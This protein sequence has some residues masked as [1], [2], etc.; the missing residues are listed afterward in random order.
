MIAIHPQRQV[1]LSTESLIVITLDN[2]YIY[3]AQYEP[4]DSLQHEFPFVIDEILY[5]QNI[6]YPEIIT[7]NTPPA[8]FRDLRVTS[9]SFYPISFNPQNHQLKI[10]KKAIVR[11]DFV[12]TDS[13]NVLPSWPASISP[14]FKNMYQSTI[15]NYNTLGIQSE[16]LSTRSQYLIISD[17]SFISLLK[18]FIFWK[19]KKGLD[20]Y[21]ESITDANR[22]TLYI[23]NL[24]KF[25]YDNYGID[26]VLL[27][28]DALEPDQP[29]YIGAPLL[30]IPFGWPH[31]SPGGFTRSDYWYSTVSGN[32]D[33]ADVAL[34]RF[35]VW[36]SAQLNT[37]IN[38]TF[39]YERYPNPNN[40]FIKKNDLVS[41]LSG[42]YHGV[43]IDSIAPMLISQ[44]F[45]YYDDYGGGA[46]N[47]DVKAHINN[48]H[49]PSKGVS[50]VNYRGGGQIDKWV[51]WNSQHED[52]TN[53]DIRSLTNFRGI[54]SAW[55]PIVFEIT[56][57]C[58]HAGLGLPDTTGHSECWLRATNG[59]GVAA[60]G[61]SRPNRYDRAHKLDAELYRV[62]FGDH[63]GAPVTQELGWVVNTAK[64][65]M[66]NAYG[67]DSITK[68][69]VRV[70]HLMGDP[71]IDVYTGWEGYISA[72]H[73][74]E[75]STGQ[76]NFLV[77]VYKSNNVP[78]GGAL[79]C[80]YKEN[81]VFETLISDSNGQALFSINPK[82]G[83]TL[84][85]TASKHNC[86]PY[87]G[88]C[89]VWD[90]GSGGQ[91]R[92]T[93]YPFTF[94]SVIYSHSYHAVAISY[95]LPRRSLVEIII[96]DV[97]GRVIYTEK[98]IKN[99]G[100]NQSIWH[101]QDSGGRI[102]NCGVYFIQLKTNQDRTM[103]KIVIF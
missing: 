100:I 20:V 2:Y 64:I 52:F 77:S 102:V 28:G 45:Q 76:Q 14:L 94:N 99:K 34:G 97:S 44:G 60:V 23:K 93:L 49:F 69:V 80:L 74:G 95:Q 83:G 68:D 29:G 6:Y 51:A 36:T 13:L 46:T 24:I 75:I 84:Y 43:K 85:V 11:A 55:L 63:L 9:I 37:V 48:T 39:A 7:C 25:Y 10:I 90:P 82:R 26:Y 42:G 5:A 57:S 72:T 47:D 88:T 56:A 3:P 30:P 22:D 101:C 70:Y 18:F 65:K 27:V 41:A 98:C 61:A 16:P 40:W 78:L 92:S 31:S 89:V 79:V 35:S 8:I 4:N 73:P 38:K 12:G 19:K 67:W 86:G 81:D 15:I 103:R 53:D 17:A 21:L 59:G 32:D 66:A 91:S 62:S 96:Y 33:I 1:Q 50:L 87:E 54:N 71:E 58:G